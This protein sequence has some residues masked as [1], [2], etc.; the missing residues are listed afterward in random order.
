M[1]PESDLTPEP[2]EPPAIED[3]DAIDGPLVAAGAGSL[4]T[5]AAFHPIDDHDP[6]EEAAIEDREAIG[7]PPVATLNV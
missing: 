3:R 7:R 2:Y 6:Y 5:A 1:E 4:P